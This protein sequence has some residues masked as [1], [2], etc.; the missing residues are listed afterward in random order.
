MRDSNKYSK[1]ILCSTFCIKLKV[2]FYQTFLALFSDFK[3]KIL[4]ALIQEIISSFPSFYD[5]YRV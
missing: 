1:V 4:E 5:L 3:T 2:C